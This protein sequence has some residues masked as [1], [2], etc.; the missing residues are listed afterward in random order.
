M[1]CVSPRRRREVSD[2]PRRK[3]LL[4]DAVEA[5]L[6]AVDLTLPRPRLLEEVARAH[7]ILRSNWR[8][9][10]PDP[11]AGS[12][13][14]VGH[15]HIDTAWLWPLRETVRKCG[16]TFSTACRLMER[17]P[18]VPLHLQPAPALPVYPA[19]I[20][21]TCI[22]RS[23]SGCRPVAGKRQAPCGWKPTAIS[24]AAN[25]SSVRCSTASPSS[26]RSSARD[27][28]MC[29]LPDVFG[30]PASL[31]EILAG[32]GVSFFYTYKLHWQAHNPFPDHLFRWRGLDGSE[33]LAHVVN[34]VWAYNNFF[35]PAHLAKGWELY[36]QKAEYP[37]VLFP[38]GFGDG[39]GGVT[40][41]QTGICRPGRPGNS[42]GCPPYASARRSSSSTTSSRPSPSCPSGMG[43]YTSRRT[44]APIPR[45][46]R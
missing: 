35:C 7:G 40:E 22:G 20:T 18:D 2:D 36:A 11:E 1:R 44:A 4:E 16:R 26:S 25:R 33:V 32:C 19:P 14:A 10:R 15:T 46:R 42:P 8:A 13:Y 9:I 17:Y 23:S 27:P 41:E 37:E 30:Y 12:L 39:G 3:A 29:W 38:F 31:P 28:R 34:H 6:L 43:N 45:S 24:P 21:R 5:A